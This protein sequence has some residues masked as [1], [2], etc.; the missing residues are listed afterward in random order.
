MAVPVS[1]RHPWSLSGDQFG[2]LRITTAKSLEEVEALRPGWLRLQGKSLPTDPDYFLTVARHHHEVVRP[3]VLLLELD[4][5]PVSLLAAHLHE[6]P[7]GHRVGAWSA[8]RPAL[9]SINVVYH[10]IL[11]DRTPV[12]VEA[13]VAELRRTLDQREADAVLLRY[14]KPGDAVHAAAIGAAPFRRREHFLPRRPHW[15]TWVGSSPDEVLNGRSAKTRENV[16]R[17]SRRLM[18]EFGQRLRLGILRRP[19]EAERL[20][21][22]IDSVAARTYQ[23]ETGGIFCNSEL[24]RELALL[25]LR[26][27]WFRAYLLYLDE[28]PIAFW[29][30]FA[31]GGTFG[32]RG[33]TG[34]DPAFRRYSPGIYVLT[35]MLED[36]SRDPAISIFDIGGGDVEYKRY[37]GDNRWEEIDVRLLAPGLRCLTVNAVGSSVQA[38][39]Q[40]LRRLG[41]A[42]GAQR[43]ATRLR[44][45]RLKKRVLAGTGEG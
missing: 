1:R 8:Y 42:G 25:G 9:R 44:N 37:F 21:A 16:R 5:T 6:G 11:G 15:S 39:H 19:S 23:H 29:T 31:Y 3:H 32:W 18:Q 45:Q 34:Y 10:G 35:K 20:F 27:G 4:G 40:G 17:I 13:L 12:M 41:A 14:L 7:L 2:D 26:K 30:G 36:L 22:D 38:L 24:E 33:A 43:S 28:R